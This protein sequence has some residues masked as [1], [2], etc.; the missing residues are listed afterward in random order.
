MVS[1]QYKK[2][3]EKFLM[4]EGYDAYEDYD[5]WE[6]EGVYVG[7]VDVQ[8]VDFGDVSYDE[9]ID[10]KLNKDDDE[11]SLRISQI[12]NFFEESPLQLNL[13]LHEFKKSTDICNFELEGNGQPF[14]RARCTDYDEFHAP[15]D[16]KK[17]SDK[18]KSLSD[19]AYG[20]GFAELRRKNLLQIKPSVWKI[21]KKD[22]REIKKCVERGDC[23][24]FNQDELKEFII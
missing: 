1:D 13:R 9:Y 18:I 3:V 16:V 22:A 20:K 14:I 17:I 11:I 2:E 7:K 8:D 10:I 4:D 12:G 5:A 21:T 19:K 24:P 23:L 15:K 6:T